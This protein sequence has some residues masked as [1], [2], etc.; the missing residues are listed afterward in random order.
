MKLDE[1]AEMKSLK[2]SWV[3]LKNKVH[4]VILHLQATKGS[5][6]Y[7]HAW[8][9]KTSGGS[10]RDFSALHF[11]RQPSHP[12]RQVV[13]L[14]IQGTKSTP[15]EN[16]FEAPKRQAPSWNSKTHERITKMTHLRALWLLWQ[17][18]PS[19]R[20]AKLGQKVIAYRLYHLQE[21]A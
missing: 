18:H 14:T 16:Q 1:V 11:D 13:W 19:I 15:G 3:L 10:S 7:N 9:I 2:H 21:T 20:M 5:G 6:M 12:G 17:L 8:K 4:A